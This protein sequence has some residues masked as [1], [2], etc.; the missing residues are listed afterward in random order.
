MAADYDETSLDDETLLEAADPAGM[1]RAVATSAAQVR[2]AA[3]ASAEA[4][5]EELRSEGLPRAVVVLGMGTSGIVGDLLAGLAGPT[6]PVPIVVY[7]NYG[8]PLWVGAA[9]VVIA[10]S[11]TGNTEETLSGLDAAARRGARVIAIGAADSPL[12]VRTV[13]ARGHFVPVPREHSARAS[14]WS[15]AVPVILAG[16]ALGLL[17]APSEEIET[18]AVRL[19]E[20]AM[21]CRPGSELFLNP[22]KL[23]AASL[24]GTV[25]VIWGGTPSTVAAAYRFAT[26]LNENAKTPAVHGGFPEAGHNQ[27]AALDGPFGALA[28]GPAAVSP[29]DSL[30][31][32]HAE[33]SA[34]RQHLVLLRDTENEL[35]PISRRLE[36][37]VDL[38]RR[39]GILVT[40]LAGE[41]E[42]HLER[43][44]SLIGLTDFAS[45]YLALLAGIDPTPMEAI[46]ALTRGDRG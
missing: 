36:V 41:G 26:L 16:D 39:R 5:I 10:V 9:D 11:A 31:V 23:L 40:E 6:C 44:A 32:D 14:L 29:E 43:L 42:S 46:A 30:F 15:M 21:R 12:H 7:K 17:T 35:T 19:V 34:T 37:A 2:A 27:V 20:V 33:D 38:A 4:G 18:M 1:L 28:H 22:A 13:T 25:P 45:V 8:L 3:L 24:A